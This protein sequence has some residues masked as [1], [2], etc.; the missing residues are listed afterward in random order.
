MKKQRNLCLHLIVRSPSFGNI[1][2]NP[3]KAATPT[4]LPEQSQSGYDVIYISEDKTPPPPSRWAEECLTTTVLQAEY[5]PEISG[6]ENNVDQTLSP[7]ILADEDLIIDDLELSA[8]NL[9]D[10]SF[11]NSSNP[12]VVCS[13]PP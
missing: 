7:S 13:T 8:E 5:I 9:D 4:F 12:F 6:G 2:L 3:E 10:S 11:W 1:E